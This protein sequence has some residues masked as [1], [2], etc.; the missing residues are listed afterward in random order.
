MSTLFL[1]CFIVGAVA[2]IG[3]LLIGEFGSSA[4]HPSDGLPFLSL[5]SIA[6]VI[7]GFGAIGGAAQLA[8]LSE[9][10]SIAVGVAGGCVLVGAFR[11]LLVPYM[12]RQQSNSHFGRTDYLGRIA[13]IEIAIPAGGWGQVSVA[14]PYGGRV[15]LKA[16]S[17]ESVDLATRTEV[18]ITDL[19][20]EFVHVVAVPEMN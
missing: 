1:L 2:L 15:R 10:V 20:P 14:D 7:F 4:G 17:S 19:D 18:V 11:G 13:V 8:Q 3:T 9:P 6:S 16:R 5:T 12:V